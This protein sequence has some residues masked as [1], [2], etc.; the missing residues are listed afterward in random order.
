MLYDAVEYETLLDKEN[1]LDAHKEDIGK[2]RTKTPSSERVSP[3]LPWLATAILLVACIDLLSLAYVYHMS[4]IVFQDKDFAANLE[5]A[6]PYIGLTELYASGKVNSSTIEPILIRPR[7][8]AQVYVD[9]PDKLAPRGE[10]DYWHETW[11]TLSPNERHLH[12]TPNAHTIV[13]FRAIDFGMEDCRLDRASFAM[14]PASRFDVFRLAAS[15][16]LD[17]SALSYRTRPKIA[18][19][20]AASL[21]ARADEE[22]EIHRFPCPRGSL[23]VFEVA[24]AEGEACMVDVWSSHNTTHGGCAV[25]LNCNREPELTG[26]SF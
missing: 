7:V 3:L 16:P 11:G 19:R 23:H 14:T 1:A 17:A 5:Y 24:C 4:G 20:V 15:R 26:P 6:D 13:Q 10:R 21:Q 8:S 25:S 18:E 12:V 9:E 2:T 22:T